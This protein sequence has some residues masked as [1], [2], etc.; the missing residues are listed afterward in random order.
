MS[1]QTFPPPPPAELLR[2][3]L[4]FSYM[5]L[6]F[7]KKMSSKESPSCSELFRLT[8]QKRGFQHLHSNPILINLTLLDN[9]GSVI[10][11]SNDLDTT[12]KLQN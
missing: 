10:C 2:M 8:D 7:P 11:Y 12:E 3:G 9:N 5:C 1:Q 6:V 4:F